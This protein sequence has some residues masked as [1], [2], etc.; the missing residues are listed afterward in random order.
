MKGNQGSEWEVLPSEGPGDG[1]PRRSTM[2][3]MALRADV[4]RREGKKRSM[5]WGTRS[6]G[7]AGMGAPG[8]RESAEPGDTGVTP[9][10]GA[11]SARW[12]GS[13]RYHDTPH[14]AGAEGQR[15]S[16]GA[17]G[18]GGA[19]AV[20]RV[21]GPSVNLRGGGPSRPC[22]PRATAMDG[23]SPPALH[24]GGPTRRPT[25]GRCEGGRGARGP[26]TALALPPPPPPLGAK[27]RQG[28][29]PT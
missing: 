11:G 6:G 28:G 27:R 4:Q 1:E 20:G 16:E 21:T 3:Y 12:D 7:P 18:L 19:R 25:A 9:I 17:Q 8:D 10:G 2:K 26:G 14:A 23:L 5:G 15:V 13:A 22:P 24:A 29:Q